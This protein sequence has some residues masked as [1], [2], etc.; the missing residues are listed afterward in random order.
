MS[1]VPQQCVG[2]PACGWCGDKNSCIQGTNRGPLAPCLRNTFLY[3]TPGSNW[4]PLKA[5]TI[6]IDTK[7]K[8]LITAH[9]DMNRVISTNTYN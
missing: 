6:N 4:N 1:T 7:G 9:P 2:N 5:G 8:L 3:N